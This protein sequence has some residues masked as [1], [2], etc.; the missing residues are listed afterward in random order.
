[1]GYLLDGWHYQLP[2][3][4]GTDDLPLLY[5]DAGRCADEEGG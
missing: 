3:R 2:D 4:T 1:M 5:E